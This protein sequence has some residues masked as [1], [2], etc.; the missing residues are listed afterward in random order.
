MQSGQLKHLSC[1][2]AL[3][4]RD[5]AVASPATVSRCGMIYM[6]PQQLGWQPLLASW[7]ATLQAQ[8]WPL[9]LPPRSSP[10]RL[11]TCMRT[12]A[13]ERVSVCIALARLTRSSQGM[14]R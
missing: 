8:A 1:S 4:A 14:R 11:G 3:Q 10:R 5:L 13:T 2:L 7:L 9:G 6:E 12:C